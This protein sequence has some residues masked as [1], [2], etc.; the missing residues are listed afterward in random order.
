MTHLLFDNKTG[1]PQ[2]EEL[3]LWKPWAEISCTC[4]DNSFISDEQIDTSPGYMARLL[5]LSRSGIHWFPD[6]YAL[7]SAFP[8]AYTPISSS[9]VLITGASLTIAPYRLTVSIS[10][11]RSS[12]PSQPAA[13]GNESHAPGAVSE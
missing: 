4:S 12:V 8:T 3:G 1:A 7:F 10:H 2:G 6:G 11:P 13:S 5:E 9:Y